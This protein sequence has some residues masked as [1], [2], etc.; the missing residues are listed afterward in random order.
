MRTIV[1]DDLRGPAIAALLQEHVDEM[2]SI[3]PPESKHALDLD[4]LRRPEVTFWSVYDDAALVGCGALK[5]LDADS[6]EVK[7][8]RTASAAQ[9]R[10]VASAV[11]AH[12]VGEARRR[13]YS[14]LYLETGSDPFFSPA[15]A[16]YRRFGFR[17]CPPFAD[18]PEDP[19]SVH[20][21]LVLT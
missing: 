5:E 12:L 19:N 16:L 20:M 14:R 17:D 15:R 1:V 6:G 18:Y 21:L 3:T 13:G 8:M 9:R 2:R 7:S 10:G 11:L 4:G